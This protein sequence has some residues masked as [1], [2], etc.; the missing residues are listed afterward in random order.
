MKRRFHIVL[1]VTAIFLL[2]AM[3]ISLIWGTYSISV[4]DVFNTLFGQGSKLQNTTIFQLRLPR[5]FIALFVGIAL[6]TAGCVLQSVTRNPLA[7]PGMIGI[8]AGAALAVVLF[9]SIKSTAYYSA[10]SAATVFMIPVF[11][12][13]GSLLSSLLIYSLAYKKGISPNRLI[14]TGIGVNAG[15]NAFITLYQLNMSKG[16]YNQALTWISGSLWGSSWI[17][18]IFLAPAVLL[19]TIIVL[20]KSRTLDVYALGDET[21]SGLGVSVQRESRILLLLAVALSALATSVAGNIAFL[22]LLGPHIAKKLVGAAHKR[23]I[24][25]GAMISAALIIAADSISRNLF[26]PLEV[27]VGITLSIVGVPYFIYLMLKEK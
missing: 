24:I 9:I 26:S 23:Q 20:Y 2:A 25:T 14:L 15:I 16:D 4:K 3:L 6:S 18:F 12:L 11:A 7:E 27:P 5:I 1:F 10:L 22:G 19:L 21:A 13:A 8:N 17:Y